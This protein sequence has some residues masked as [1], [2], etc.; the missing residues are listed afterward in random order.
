[1]FVTAGGDTDG[2]I[3]HLPFAPEHALRELIHLHTG[4]QNLIAGI[5]GAMRNG[6]AIAEEG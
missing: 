4:L 3:R 5:G 1:M 2:D 6:D